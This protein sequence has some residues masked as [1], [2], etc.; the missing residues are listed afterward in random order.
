MPR[1][2][3]SEHVAKTVLES[4]GY[5]VLGLRHKVMIGDVEAGEIDI[6]AE[7]QGVKYAVE[8]K[9]GRAS[10]TDIRQA[11][12][13]ATAAGMAP[14]II[15]KGYADEAA[16]AL[17]EKLGVK[18]IMLPEYYLVTPEEIREA[19]ER[20]L[21]DVLAELFRIPQD[22]TREDQ[23]L[24]EKISSS[25]TLEKLAEK[26][27]V[28]KS[29]AG[30]LLGDLKRRKILTLK[31]GYQTLRLQATTILITLRILGLAGEP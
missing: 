26:L 7:K 24:L 23:I 8:V 22:L 3:T 4:L 11:Y 31:G 21:T 28:D 29:T 9:A 15:A 20:A 19:M 10:L 13:N 16:R 2:V 25:P 6:V 14:L 5:Q 30:K 18:L 12:S 17:A 27:G 1:G